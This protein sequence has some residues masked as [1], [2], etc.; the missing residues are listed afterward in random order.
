ML[1]RQWAPAASPNS[2]GCLFLF[3]LLPMDG[4]FVDY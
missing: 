3:L 4:N 1:A 2:R